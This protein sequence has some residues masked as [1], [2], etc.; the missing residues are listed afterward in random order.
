MVLAFGI[1]LA[2]AEFD[3]SYSPEVDGQV[4]QCS[5]GRLVP[6]VEALPAIVCEAVDRRIRS[7]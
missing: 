5:A 7:A 2:E 4:I 6:N 1:G 3:A